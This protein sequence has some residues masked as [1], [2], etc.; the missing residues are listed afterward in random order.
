MRVTI[1]TLFVL[2]VAKSFAQDTTLVL[3]TRMYSQNQTITLGDK[4][5]W[6]FKLGSNPSWAIPDLDVSDWQKLKPVDL[7]EKMA[8]EEG[9]LEGWFRIKI[10][11]DSSFI[12]SLAGIGLMHSRWS[13]ADVYVDGKLFHSFNQTGHG[14]DGL[15]EY[16][17]NLQTPI[18]ISL[19]T[20][21][22][23]FLAIHFVEFLNP[24]NKELRS[25][26]D[27]SSFISLTS[28]NYIQQTFLDAT[29]GLQFFSTVTAVTLILTLLFWLIY[30]QNKKEINLFI[31]AI[32]ISLL[33]GSLLCLAINQSIRLSYSSYSIILFLGAV[34]I[35]AF[36]ISIPIVV[37]QLFK[38]RI[39]LWH[40]LTAGILFLGL[41]YTYVT[42]DYYEGMFSINAIS[43]LIICAY[44][45]ISSR[46]ILFG[47]RWAVVAGL[48]APVLLVILNMIFKSV[49]FLNV[50]LIILSLLSFPLS[51][52][53]YVAL[54]IKE[55]RKAIEVNAEKVIKLSDEKKSLL[56]AQNQMLEQQ[57]AMRTSELNQ[58]LESL[59]ST[60]AQ[61]IQSEKMASLGELTAGIAHEI[62]NPLNFVNNFSEINRELAIELE[63]EIDKG[64]YSDAKALAKDIR[65]NEEKINLHGKRADAIVK[66]MLQH[67][68]SSSGQK[69][70]TDINALCDEYLRLSYHGL[71]AKDP[72]FNASFHFE[73]DDSLPK[74]NVVPQDIGRVLLNLINNAF[75]AVSERRKVE[76]ENFNP[77]VKVST[78]HVFPPAGG[79]R[80]AKV[81]RWIEISLKDNGPGIPDSII[82]KIFQPFFT[83]KPTGQGTGLGLSLSYDIVKAHGGELKVETNEARPDE[84]FGRGEGSTFILQL[85]T[86]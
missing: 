11:L 40:K 17:D 13:A 14:T 33:S 4:V 63:E 19:V 85:P 16:N 48:V 64:N 37:G 32:C 84:P 1:F 21:K 47:A 81:S 3:S 53:V 71:K 61:L 69:E 20:E 60:Q 26:G 70:L 79:L 25:V 44:Y 80:G 2:L 54:W 42:M 62:Q 35:V 56:A 8:D 18:S 29:L 57:V 74:L 66:G 28:P 76:G 49:D 75:Q 9:R 67:S 12:D 31:I 24:I 59:K 10:K 78:K 41:M 34:L 23:Y 58:S 68:K 83:T 15:N 51:L 65:G 52:L 55:S 73:P 27:L 30:F 6:I 46:K 45:I 38:K 50:V 86:A 72:S 77:E 22:E 82:D 39:A 43:S 36:F 7:T 5:G